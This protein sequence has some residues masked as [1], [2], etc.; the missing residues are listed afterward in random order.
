M[1]GSIK[2]SGLSNKFRRDNYKRQRMMKVFEEGSHREESRE[3]RDST[4]RSRSRR[5]GAEVNSKDPKDAKTLG[6]RKER[7]G[8]K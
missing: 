8:M 5:S 3:E 1:V 7:K 4:Q 6:S 2:E